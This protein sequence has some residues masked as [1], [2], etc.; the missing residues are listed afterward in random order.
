MQ[1]SSSLF[2]KFASDNVGNG[3]RRP[4]PKDTEANRANEIFDKYS[5]T[6]VT[7][8]PSSQGRNNIFE[9][10]SQSFN[11]FNLSIFSILQRVRLQLPR[12]SAFRSFTRRN[13]AHEEQLHLTQL[14]KKK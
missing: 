7:D 8:S 12:N 13:M 5:R 11:L 3:F 1:S 2:R 4:K 10:S 9:T 6:T 14:Q